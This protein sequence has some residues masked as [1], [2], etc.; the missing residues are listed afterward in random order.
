[1]ALLTVIGMDPPVHKNCGWAVVGRE[2][3]KLT[4]FEK[5]TQVLD[6][7]K[8]DVILEEVYQRLDGLI[9]QY[10]PTAIS[11]ERQQG[12]GFAFG[13]A[14]LNEFVGVIK[15]CAYRRSVPVFEISPA[16]MKMLIAGHGKAPKEYVMANIAKT[17]NLPE[18]GVEHECDAVAF[19]INHFIDSGWAGYSIKQAYTKELA[20]ADLEAKKARKLAREEKQRLKAA[21]LKKK[22]RKV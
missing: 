7:T 16:H 4:L 9:S 21:G 13:R 10:L 11:I 2:D 18:T 8:G 5:F 14:K 1:M 6:N 20:K 19:A 15:L 12:T 17:F 22:N 3:D